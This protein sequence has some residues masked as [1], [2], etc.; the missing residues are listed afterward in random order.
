MFQCIK[1]INLEEIWPEN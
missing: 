1:N